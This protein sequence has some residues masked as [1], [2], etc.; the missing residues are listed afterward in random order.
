MNLRKALQQATAAR[1]QLGS[2]AD[3]D[4]TGRMANGRRAS[5]GL[6]WNAPQYTE[7]RRVTIDVETAVRNHCIALSPTFEALA[8][9]KVLRTQLQQMSRQKA[10][11]TIMVTSASPGEG[12][13]VTAI[14]LAVTFAREYDQTMLLV[15]ADF[16]RQ[17]I[18]RYLGYRSDAGLLDYLAER[19]PMQA[20]ITCSEIEKFTVISGG[21]GIDDSSEIIGSPRMQT[22][23]NDLKSRYEDRYVIFDVPAILNAADA[24][25]F[26]PLVDGIVVVVGAGISRQQDLIK[27]LDMLPTEKIA[28]FVLNKF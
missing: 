5:A 1:N 6:A 14:N 12:K 17:Q 7:S 25:A 3:A 27:A 23:V 8:G 10:W 16:G 4:T 18:H 21:R 15:D 11:K 20:V 28:G 19:A 9:Y 24:L 26:A 2:S 22:L 13:T